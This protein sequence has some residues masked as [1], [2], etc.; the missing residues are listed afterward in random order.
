MSFCLSTP[1]RKAAAIGVRTRQASAVDIAGAFNNECVPTR[2]HG[3]CQTEDKRGS[4]MHLVDGCGD[5]LRTGQFRF[6]AIGFSGDHSFLVQPFIFGLTDNYMLQE[7]SSPAV[8]Y[9]W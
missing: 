5:H 4:H 8:Q 6:S 7:V 1:L 9:G 2:H 3:C